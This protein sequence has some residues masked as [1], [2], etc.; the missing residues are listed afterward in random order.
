MAKCKQC[1]KDIALGK[2]GEA[3]LK[4]HEKSESHRKLSGASQLQVSMDTLTIPP[5][6]PSA[7]SNTKTTNPSTSGLD[8][9]ISKTDVLKAE[10]MWTIQTVVN[11]NS[12]KSN[13]TSNRAFKVSRFADF[14][15]LEWP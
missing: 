15:C 12:Y 6:P 5:P 13:E 10:V 7:S 3:A 9:F 1:D 11:H 14:L 4:S 8:K 2:M